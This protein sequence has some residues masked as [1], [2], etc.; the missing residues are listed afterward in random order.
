MDEFGAALTRGEVE[1]AGDACRIEAEAGE[2]NVEKREVECCAKAQMT[3]YI[4]H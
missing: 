2:S 1:R 3:W 4:S